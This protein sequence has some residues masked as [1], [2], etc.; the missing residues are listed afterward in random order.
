[1]KKIKNPYGIDFRL[2]EMLEPSKY[3]DDEYVIIDRKETSNGNVILT[4]KCTFNSKIKYVT[5]P[6]Y[7][8]NRFNVGDLIAL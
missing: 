8:F 5:V 7:Y 1:M 6:K 4:A 2:E 3:I